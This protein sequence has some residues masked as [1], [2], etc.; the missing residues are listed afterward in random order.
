MREEIISF[1]TGM[2]YWAILE[3]SK[4]RRL[5][6]D[7]F[8]GS[9][10]KEVEFPEA[11]KFCGNMIERNTYLIPCNNMVCNKVMLVTL[12]QFSLLTIRLKMYCIFGRYLYGIPWLTTL[13]LLKTVNS[14]N[15]VTLKFLANLNPARL[16]L[17]VFEIFLDFLCRFSQCLYFFLVFQKATI[18]VI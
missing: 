6:E 11:Q 13:H 4:Q 5:I 17:A 3:I 2:C 7:N 15:K 12:L 10:K 8:Q 14:L 18:Y 16:K 1:A 9:I